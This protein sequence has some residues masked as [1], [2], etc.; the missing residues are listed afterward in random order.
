[1]VAE[2]LKAV[3]A[4]EEEVFPSPWPYSVLA[5]ELLLNDS[6]SAFVAD[7]RGGVVG[8]TFL[9]IL[10]DKAHLINIA[11]DKA[12]RG[13]GLGEKLL[14]SA[15]DCA[16]QRAAADVSLEVRET[17]APAIALYREHGFKITG[18]TEDYYADNTAA[19]L[20]K[21]A[22]AAGEIGKSEAG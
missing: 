10:N 4:I 20:M 8:Y 15:L 7:G 5:Y 17:N 18:K 1:M 12:H 22:I 11:V 14:S 9:R 19:L 3:A 6:C 16:A 13:E 21:V 2:D